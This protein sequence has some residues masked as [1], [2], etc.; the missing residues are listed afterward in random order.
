MVISGQC[1]HIGTAIAISHI[2]M[3]WLFMWTLV[4]LFAKKDISKYPDGVVGN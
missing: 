3:N 1:I 4:N 2:V